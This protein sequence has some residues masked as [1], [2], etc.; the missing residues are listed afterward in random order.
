[1]KTETPIPQPVRAKAF[2]VALLTIVVALLAT[3]A[4]LAFLTTIIERK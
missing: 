1:M 2:R 4:G 3:V